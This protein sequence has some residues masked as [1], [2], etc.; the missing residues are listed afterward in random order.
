[1]KLKQNADLIA[2]GLLAAGGALVIEHAPFLYVR[3]AFALLLL[4]VFP[5]YAITQALFA[6]RPRS[7]SQLSLLTIGL[8]L[9]VSILTA[10]VLSL[11]TNGLRAGSWLIVVVALVLGACWAAFRRRQTL[12]AEQ[13]DT[14]TRPLVPV[15]VRV[16]ARDV[17][18]L[19]LASIVVVGALVFAFRPLP[20]KNVQGYTALAIGQASAG[21]P[22]TVRVSVTS[23]ELSTRLYRVEVTSGSKVTYVNRIELVP[24][25]RWS[26]TVRVPSPPRGQEVRVEAAI[27]WNY[28][29]HTKYRSVHLWL[30]AERTRD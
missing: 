30:G 10:L 12:D 22:P 1:L 26:A 20:A 4:F 27:Y 3:F 19:V 2:T 17:I 15:R 18:L 25:E 24:G 8:S 23:Q 13:S 16:R 5:G 21:P 29:P 9:S 14:V 11:A 6:G 28:E 7:L